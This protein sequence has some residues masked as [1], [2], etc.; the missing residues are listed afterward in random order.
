MFVVVGSSCSYFST[1][2]KLRAYHELTN[3]TDC[4]RDRLSGNKA[5]SF[6]I[7][8]NRTGSSLR[9][10]TYDFFSHAL[11][12]TEIKINTKNKISCCSLHQCYFLFCLVY[13]NESNK[14]CDVID[15]EMGVDS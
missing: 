11:R 6:I 12:P 7:L 3:P 14:C 15:D 1:S 2:S 10:N 13:G 4:V 5:I 9:K 8:A